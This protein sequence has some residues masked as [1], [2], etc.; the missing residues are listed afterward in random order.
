MR[1]KETEKLPHSILIS[2][3]EEVSQLRLRPGKIPVLIHEEAKQ[4]TGPVCTFRRGGEKRLATVGNR[5]V[6]P[7]S[8]PVY[9]V[10][11]SRSSAY[12]KLVIQIII[13]TTFLGILKT[14][15]YIGLKSLIL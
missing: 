8:L 12:C 15:F 14:Y 4:V 13:H 5:I 10:G 7:L 6:Q 2:S 1:I 9:R 3:L 11:F